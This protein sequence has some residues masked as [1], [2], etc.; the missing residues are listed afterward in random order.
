MRPLHRFKL[1]SF[2]VILLGF[3]AVILI[4]AFLL[5]LPTSSKEGVVTP[6]SDALFTS[7]SAVCVTGLIV[8]DTATYWSYFG[9]AIILI[10][11]QIGGLG[12]VTV[13]ASV[14][15]LPSQEADTAD[16]DEQHNYN[17]DYG[18]RGIGGKRR[19]LSADLSHHVKSCVTEC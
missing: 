3:A 2:Q 14:Y 15:I 5:M 17:A 19:I 7:T 10:L 9:Q 12:V 16:Y 18:M 4:G 11:I 1:S 6:F 13:A 8:Q